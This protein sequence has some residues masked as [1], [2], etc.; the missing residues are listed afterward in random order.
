MTFTEADVDASGNAI[1]AGTAYQAY[2]L[3]IADGTNATV[4]R[5]SD[6]SNSAALTIANP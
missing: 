5:L 2:V 4:N 6:P 1:T 3:S